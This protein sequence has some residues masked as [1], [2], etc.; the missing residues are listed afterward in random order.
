MIDIDSVPN[1]QLNFEGQPDYI[2]SSLTNQDYYDLPV[3]NATFAGDSV[4]GQFYYIDLNSADSM[5]FDINCYQY[6]DNGMYQIC[7]VAPVFADELFNAVENTKLVSEYENFKG[8]GF[9]TTSNIYEGQICFGNHCKI[10]QF[11]SAYYVD[12]DTQL[13]NQYA[14]YGVIGLGMYSPVWDA[15]VDTN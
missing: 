4:S 8:N 15:Y 5:V 11:Y 10:S 9:N 1:Q 7:G 2:R 6:L 13:Y 3:F 14:S 12:E